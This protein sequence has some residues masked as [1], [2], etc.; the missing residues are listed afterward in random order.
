M[1]NS[2][3]IAIIGI[4]ALSGVLGLLRGAIREILG[5]I[6]LIVAA[7]ASR[8]GSEY[9]SAMLTPSIPSAN[10]VGLLSLALP[11]MV[12]LLIWG[13]LAGMLA[14]RLRPVVFVFLTALWGLCLVYCVGALLSRF[15]T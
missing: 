1:L 4:V 5:F 10:A 15:F 6:G 2:I 7:I 3:D 9:V 12:V 14:P 8:L 11:F 13:V